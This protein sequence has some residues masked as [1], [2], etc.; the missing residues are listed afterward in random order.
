MLPIFDQLILSCNVQIEEEESFLR[1]FVIVNSYWLLLTKTIKD[2]T[3]REPIN[4]IT[5]RLLINKHK[6]N[7][8]HFYIY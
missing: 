4:G 2:T 1:W 8:I 5:S 3:N 7:S 6:I